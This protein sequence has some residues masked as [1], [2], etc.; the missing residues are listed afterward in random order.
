MGKRCKLPCCSL[1]IEDGREVTRVSSIKY[2]G[3]VITENVTFS[4][5]ADHLKKAFNRACNAILS[6]I[7]GKASEQLVMHLIKVKC[8]PILL[9][10]IEAA[11]YKKSTL[12]SMDFALTRFVMRIFRTGSA[13]IAHECMTCMGVE[14]PSVT[15][16]VRRVQFLQKCVASD[17]HYVR[18]CALRAVD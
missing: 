14:L 18:M 6:K 16:A 7:L 2:L 5:S 4:W 10:A 1:L 12:T 17:N 8:L 13:V 11:V 15:C 3:I 9:Y